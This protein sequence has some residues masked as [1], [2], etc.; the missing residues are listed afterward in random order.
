MFFPASSNETPNPVLDYNYSCKISKLPSARYR[1]SHQP[2]DRHCRPIELITRNEIK[3]YLKVD[4]GCV[5]CCVTSFQIG[6]IVKKISS[7]LVRLHV[8]YLRS[9]VLDT[10]CT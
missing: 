7:M 3:L 8:P 5:L 1:R 2:E 10:R 4:N 6:I 9:A